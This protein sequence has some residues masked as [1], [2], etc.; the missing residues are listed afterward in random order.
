MEETLFLMEL[1]VKKLS[2]VAELMQPYFTEDVL[3]LQKVCDRYERYKLCAHLFKYIICSNTKM[4]CT[5]WYWKIPGA[6]N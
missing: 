5:Q 6:W 1:T 2:C 3:D 4:S